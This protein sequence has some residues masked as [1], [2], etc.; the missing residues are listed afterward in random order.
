M[1]TLSKLPEQ[2]QEVK[3]IISEKPSHD[4]FKFVQKLMIETPDQISMWKSL[5]R[6]MAD[7]SELWVWEF[8]WFVRDASTLPPYHY[9]SVKDRNELS[10]QIESLTKELSKKLKNNGLDGHIVLFNEGF[11]LLEDLDDGKQQHYMDDD[12]IEK[13]PLSTLL[14]EIGARCQNVLV[15]RKMEKSGFN[16]SYFGHYHRQSLNVVFFL[17]LKKME[18]GLFIQ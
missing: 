15:Q 3:N 13:L 1:A 14:N 12:N 7:I 8:L 9:M 6:Q 10:N 2:V 17:F 18:K 5:E 11:I 16:I 4:L